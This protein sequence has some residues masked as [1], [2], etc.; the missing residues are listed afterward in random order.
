VTSVI[1]PAHDEQAVLGRLLRRLTETGGPEAAPLRVVVVC[2][3][4]S[5]R[6]GEVARGY[7]GVTVV[8]TP[9]ASK[10]AALRLGDEHAVDFPRVYVDADVEIDATSVQALA[11]ALA[12]G[13]V[14]AAAPRRVI[15][16]GAASWPVRW[17]YD[18]WETIPGVRAGLFGRGV[19]AVSAAGHQ[20]LRGLPPLLSDDLAASSVFEDEERA[21]VPDAVVTVHPPRTW[22]DLVRRRVRVV[23]GTR[24]AYEGTA[25]ESLRTDSR[26][27]RS[28]LLAAVRAR[29]GL[30]I[31]LPVFLATTMVARRRAAR[32]VAAGDYSTWLRDESSR[33]T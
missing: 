2:N 6:T 24:Q 1:I 27:G 20:R 33:T 5:D 12:P 10:L 16:R 22:N 11:A 18:V 32:A 29:P 7:P 23:T 19:V 4:C 8:E 3:G 26:T 25:R 31:K 21:I 17:Y 13:S 9:V 15:P 30:W 14:L 28:D